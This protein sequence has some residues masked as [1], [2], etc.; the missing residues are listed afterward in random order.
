VLAIARP[1]IVLLQLLIAGAGWWSVVAT[2]GGGPTLLRGLLL[3][4]CLVV[5]ASAT[6]AVIGSF[7]CVGYAAFIRS[8]ADT[9]TAVIGSEVTSRPGTSVP[10]RTARD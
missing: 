4:V 5:A 6:V 9:S 8:S 3:I 10:V 1:G 7:A 2:L